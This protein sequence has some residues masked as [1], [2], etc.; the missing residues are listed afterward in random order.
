MKRANTR[1]NRQKVSQEHCIQRNE[2]IL[3]T[4]ETRKEVR[5]IPNVPRL[6]LKHRQ[7]KQTR[8]N[9]QNEKSQRIPLRHVGP[10]LRQC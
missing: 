1:Q 8:I 5:R 2:E 7:N 10:H 4:T 6:P 9:K 3:K